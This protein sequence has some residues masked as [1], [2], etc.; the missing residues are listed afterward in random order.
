MK[1]VKK[2]IAVFLT[3][4]TFFSICSTATT[5]FAAEY[6]KEK[7]RVEYFDS[8]LSEYLK[9]IIDTDNAVS[10][11]EKTDN[12]NA[13]TL[14]AEKAENSAAVQSR[15]FAVMQSAENT[16]ENETNNEDDINHERLTLEL[17]NGENKAYIFSEPISYTDEDGKLEYK[18]TNI[19]NTEDEGILSQGYAFTNG[20]NDYKIYFSTDSKKGVMLKSSKGSS[21]RMRPATDISST[22]GVF[23]VA[24]DTSAVDVFAYNGAFGFGTLL[25]YIPQLNGCKEEIILDRYTGTNEFSFLMET[26]E[27]EAK[28]NALGQIEIYNPETFE[29]L[30]TFNAPYAYDAL[31]EMDISSSH[32]SECEYVL[33]KQADGEYL[34]K[35]VVPE[36]F[37]TSENTVY[38]VTIDPT[39][40]NLSQYRDAPIYSKKSTTSFHSNEINC[41]GKTSDY[42]YGRVLTYFDIPEDIKDYA[43]INSAYIWMREVT[44]RTHNMYVKPFIVKDKWYN[45]VTWATQP[46]Y[47][48]KTCNSK[49]I[50]S[51]SE[52]GKGNYWYK[53]D[54]KKAVKAWTTGTA[55][56]GLI[57]I[58]KCD[59][60]QDSHYYWYG[61]ASKEHSTSSYRPYAVINYKNDT[62]PPTIDEITYT[63]KGWTKEN[64]TITVKASD[65][66]SGLATKAYSFDGGKTWQASNK[67]KVPKNQTVPIWVIDKAGNPKK[68]SIKITN[69]DKTAPTI[70]KV[71]LTPSAWTNGNVKVTVTA[72]DA[73]SGLAS[74]PYSFDGGK[75]W[76]KENYKSFSTNCTVSILVRDAV[77][78]PTVNKEANIVKKTIS[79]IDK[80]LPTVTITSS[81]TGDDATI[82]VNASD[83]GSGLHATAYSFDGGKTWVSSK[84]K[85][86]A[87]ATEKYNIWVRD[88]ANN[89]YKK[90]GYMPGAYIVA[91]TTDWTN[92]N[93]TLT[94]IA[95]D[96]KE[97]SFDG[98]QTWSTSSSKT[99][100]DNCTVSARV[101]TNSGNIISLPDY[102]ISNID[103]IDPNPPTINEGNG[104]ITITEN[105]DKVEGGSAE[106]L[107]YSIGNN[108]DWK[109]YEGKPIE[110]INSGD[111][112]V[113]ARA[114]DEA[115]NTSAEVALVVKNRVGEYV[116]SYSDLELSD[117]VFPISFGRTYSSSRGWNFDFNTDVSLTE[118]VIN[119]NADKY[120]FSDIYGETFTFESKDGKFVCE[121]IG[122]LVIS[123]S[124]YTVAS[125]GLTYSFEK[126]NSGSI[127]L[128][129]ISYENTEVTFTGSNGRLSSI[130]VKNS[131]NNDFRE[132]SYSWESYI[133]NDNETRYRLSGFTDVE[134][135]A[136]TYAYT[137]GLMTSNDGETISYNGQ[138][139]SRIGQKN[140]AYVE[141]YY[142]EVK[143]DNESPITDYKVI[144]VDSKDVVDE[145]L[146]SEGFAITGS[147]GGYSDNARL[148]EEQETFSDDAVANGFFIT[149]NSEDLPE[150]NKTYDT[151]S[152]G[153]YIFYKY[154]T[155]NSEKLIGVA[156]VLSEKV[157]DIENATYDTVVSLAYSVENYTYEGDNISQRL[158]K[159]ADENG[160][161]VNSEKVEYIYTDGKL[162]KTTQ[163]VYTN[164]VWTPVYI[165]AIAY[166]GDDV[167][168]VPAGGKTVTQ[169][170]ISG[171]TTTED[172]IQYDFWGNKVSS[173]ST[174]TV[175]EN[176]TTETYGYVYDKFNRITEINIPKENN[177]KE[178]VSAYLYDEM[179][180]LTSTVSEGKTTA[181]QYT[182]GDLI[183]RTNNDGSVA[184]YTYDKGNLTS[185]SFN[186]YNFTYNTLGSIL[187]AKV[188]EQK[189]AEYKYSSDLKQNVTQM[190]F[191]NDQV[192][193]Y[194]YDDNGNVTQVKVGD[195][196][197]F[198]YTYS[199]KTDE[200]GETIKELSEITDNINNLKKIIEEDKLTVKNI[201]G[202]ELY[203]IQSHTKNEDG[204][205]FDGTTVTIDNNKAYS[206]VN[207]ENKDTFNFQNE[208]DFSKNYEYNSENRIISA[209]IAALSLA[210]DYDEEN[211]GNL[212]YSLG[213]GATK[214]FSYQY[215]ENGNIISEQVSIDGVS[216]DVTAYE[217]DEDNQLVS[218]ENSSTKWTYSYD[219][220]GNLTAENE[221]SVSVNES[222]EKVYTP[223]ENGTD[224]YAY[225]AN[226]KDKLTS[227]NGQTISYDNSGNPTSYLGHNLTWTMGRQ[228]SS[229]DNTTYTYNES[230]IRTSKTV[231]EN[232]TEF[233]LNGTNVIYQTDGE[234]D[235][236]FFYDRNNEL[237]GFKYSG[238]NYFYVKNQ[239]GDITDIADENGNIVASYTYDPWGS[240]LSV[241]G[242]DTAIGNL[243]PFRYRSY[244]YDSDIQM[245]YLQSRYY[246]PG[247]GRFINCDDVNYIG[248][249]E[250][251]NSYN[252]FAYCENEPVG[253]CDPYGLYYIKVS[254]MAQ[255]LIYIIGFNPIGA[256]LLYVGYRRLKMLIVAKLAIIGAR[257]GGFYIPLKFAIAVLFGVLGFTIGSSIAS[258]LW[259]CANTGKKGIEFV[260]RRN[261]WGFPYKLDIYAR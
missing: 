13:L 135:H 89:I 116:A 223:K 256:T 65:S 105:P 232:T 155:G 50:N 22:G 103:N 41:F 48:D 174:T 189:L 44:G 131:K 29:V 227:Y 203:S 102:T 104:V 30:D 187:T 52:D 251:I 85:T 88:V 234:T 206:V 177:T 39:T 62:T 96:A 33:T 64:V 112:T 8:N 229:F 211:V 198:I 2:I 11:K 255:V 77:G 21:V 81:V 69:I 16:N 67:F 254:R 115:T 246:D 12:E 167:I 136:H 68:T 31:N 128:K 166:V 188:G 228:L 196:E 150:E 199:D 66:E 113:F 26:G 107:E 222:G 84:T 74:T 27:A 71:E 141:Y 43:T 118:S 224:S 140:G 194:V 137:D 249:S 235:I 18:E 192:I 252:A 73:D 220:R 257:L 216:A 121:D 151:D 184:T 250:T 173:V 208:L 133:N 114:V 154:E 90:N 215:D 70:S 190:T 123:D 259:E 156:Y 243:N 158:V 244:Y 53:F 210:Y 129:A 86:D 100:S 55:N 225:D 9:D 93:V 72:S 236:Y 130:N 98:G 60:E 106:H 139:V 49:L 218:A 240:V 183:S 143:A 164:G 219:N 3:I 209:T 6:V 248:Y 36:E 75:T 165:E 126:D 261:R 159:T 260:I 92:Q 147:I 23:Q 191:G 76:Q 110:I 160:N 153:N 148:A 24:S 17:K 127:N 119:G 144:S 233:Y 122:E 237:V 34:I 202:T 1:K 186:G 37:L 46:T 63:P 125:D 212:S 221:Y 5:V 149:D 258:A 20:K 47:G 32:Y 111:V 99:F 91:N 175:G 207:E 231:G 95:T 217:Y 195:A 61:F 59:L 101:R 134:N 178:I 132:V 230:G 120:I 214:N 108:T 169:T 7:E 170:T 238:N 35:T 242:S 172:I 51:A 204:T 10:I 87:K 14:K 28:I 25:R 179:G 117:D 213:Q 97:Y 4:L 162:I 142:S 180:N 145:H 109:T 56:R 78:N 226:W 79:N 168:K 82:T 45:A 247:V 182:N 42:G 201:S 239:M 146:Y 205:G 163:S 161:L 38:P 80:T 94:I 152:D 171:E 245:Y 176:V 54:I 138:R 124:T 15:A 197:K 157:T 193:D 58:C 83:T 185:H 181:Y 241:T 40:S 200:D 253:S 19:V 57:F